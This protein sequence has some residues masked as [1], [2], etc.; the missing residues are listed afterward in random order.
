M[1]ANVYCALADLQDV[2]SESGVTLRSDDDPPTTLGGAIAKAGNTIDRYLYRRYDPANLVQSNTIKDLAAAIACFYLSTRRG[3]SPPPGVAIQYDEAIAY[4]TEVKS[5]QNEIP[6]IAARKSYVPVISK[7][8]ATLRPYPRTVVERSQGSHA[9]GEP[10]NY[11]QHTDPYDA[12]GWNSS[13]FLNW[14]I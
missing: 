1:T 4:L 7:M 12:T 6:G 13:S 2:L 10:E 9:T 8:R 11:P 5:G 3:N 14:S